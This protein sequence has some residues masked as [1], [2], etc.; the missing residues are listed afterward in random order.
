ME[1]LILIIA[2]I[3]F[4]YF[5]F[6]Q[7][8][9]Q[10]E[11]ERIWFKKSINGDLYKYHT[12]ADNVPFI[13]NGVKSVESVTSYK[14]GEIN[15]V[16]R[17]FNMKGKETLIIEY[18][19]GKKNGVYKKY[20]QSGNPTEI[21]HYIND[22]LNGDYK[23]YDSNG[24][25]IKS[26]SYKDNL[27]GDDWK[28]YSSDNECIS[29]KIASTFEKTEKVR[30]NDKGENFRNNAVVDHLAHEIQRLLLIAERKGQST[31]N[32]TFRSFI[33]Y[34]IKKD[35]A[36]KAIL[37][38][39][40]AKKAWNIVVNNPVTAAEADAKAEGIYISF[41]GI[42]VPNDMFLTVEDVSKPKVDLKEENKDDSKHIPSFE[43]G[44]M[45]EFMNL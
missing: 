35:G 23:L 20:S 6:Q 44:T 36:P 1:L 5:Y 25:L 19:D 8:I 40:S 7:I 41:F 42:S 43:E 32:F 37:N 21:K 14:E 38:F 10:K 3:I 2:A 39:N 22:E 30:I 28:T 4:F 27:K 34:L 18:K 13:R 15:G 17:E 12:Y 26:G 11:H 24:F 16:Y 9:N 29:S 45:D 33:A 31:K